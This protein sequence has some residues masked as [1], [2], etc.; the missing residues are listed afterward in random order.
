MQCERCGIEL[1]H[2]GQGHTCRS[3][4]VVPDGP[5][6]GW[7]VVTWLVVGFA[8]AFTASAVVLAVMLFA[9][10]DPERLG[11]SPGLAAGVLVTTVLWLVSVVGVLVTLIIWNRRTRRLAEAY[12]ADGRTYLRHWVLRVY[13]VT[14]LVTLFLQW[15]LGV[16]QGTGIVVGAAIRA[17]GGVALITGVLIGRTR[18]LS[19]IAGSAEQSR[20]AQEYPPV[21]GGVP[22][23][24]APLPATTEPGDG[25]AS[26]W[27]PENDEDIVER[28]RRITP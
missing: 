20:V 22:G 4:Y 15:G 13:S 27:D 16:S 25:D 7:V 21:A 5:P 19:L 8:A 2:R 28:W 17:L 23:P 3:V 26:R 14:V 9:L 6:I 12:G 18:I 11:D 1:E 10:P 24:R